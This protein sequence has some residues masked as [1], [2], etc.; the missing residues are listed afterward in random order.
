MPPNAVFDS[1]FSVEAQAKIRDR[2][3]GRPRRNPRSPDTRP[4]GGFPLPHARPRDFGSAR[5]Q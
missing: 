1:D 3:E 2:D 4:L 5:P